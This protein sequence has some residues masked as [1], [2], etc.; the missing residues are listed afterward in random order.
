MKNYSQEI[1]D[2]IKQEPERH[3]VLIL[4]ADPLPKQKLQIKLNKF[5]RKW[6]KKSELFASY[7][8]C[9]KCKY[10]TRRPNHLKR[11]LSRCARNLSIRAKK[12]PSSA[13]SFPPC[14][15]ILSTRGNISRCKGC[16]VE[17][18]SNSAEKKIYN[19]IICSKEF[20]CYRCKEKHFSQACGSESN[21][22]CSKNLRHLHDNSDDTT[23]LGTH[24]KKRKSQLQCHCD[25]CGKIFKKRNVKDHMETHAK[26]PC[27]I[28]HHMLAKRRLNNHM[29]QHRDEVTFECNLCG[30]FFSTMKSLRRHK[31]EVHENEEADLRKETFSKSTKMQLES[32]NDCGRPHR[33]KINKCSAKFASTADQSKHQKMHIGIGCFRCPICETFES[34]RSDYVM[35]HIM[36][37]H[38][39]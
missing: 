2:N 8:F 37:N 14:E 39:H 31:R 30:N 24:N 20:S 28:C 5:D 27:P 19:C 18:K 22:K 25:I 23:Y 38:L 34:K 7:F 1:V 3:Y 11:H 35:R 16:N 15:K 33:C 12:L 29:E 13:R 9:A 26:I 32:L 17:S 10:T 4:P 36:M 21:W 6:M